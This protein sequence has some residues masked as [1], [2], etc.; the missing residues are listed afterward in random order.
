MKHCR[1]VH[2]QFQG[3]CEFIGAFQQVLTIVQYQ[4]APGSDTP[5]PIMSLGED[6]L[7][8]SLNGHKGLDDPVNEATRSGKLHTLG[9]V[10]KSIKVRTTCYPI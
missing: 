3:N 7:N 6:L 9:D 10:Q 8:L 2:I 1:S 4:S 5:V